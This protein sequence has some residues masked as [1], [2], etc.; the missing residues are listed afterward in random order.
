MAATNKSSVSADQYSCPVCLEV[1]KEPVTLV[2]GHS[3]CMDCIND[4]WDKSDKEETY[5][6]PQCR[7]TFNER[8]ELNKNTVLT[9][10]IEKLKES[11]DDGGDS[12][13]YAGP[14]DVPCDVC[15][16]RKLRAVKSCLTCMAS[17]CETHLQP[18]RRSEVLNRHKLEDPSGNLEEK[19]CTKHQEV[20]KIFC[21]T[22]DT[23]V[24]LLCA[25]TEHKS[26]DTVTPEEARAERQCQV[27]ERKEETK[28]KI[29]EKEKKLE[30]IKDAIEKI[31]SS[32][33]REVE[34]LEEAFKSLLKT[35]E[36][37]RSE[38]TEVIRG[39]ERREVTKAEELI[40]QLEEDIKELKRR[41]AEL[42]ELSQTDDHIHFLK[43]LPSIYFLLGD[44]ETGDIS[45]NGDLLPETLKMSLS[46]LKENLQEINGWEFL[47]TSEPGPDVSGHIL[48]NLQTRNGL[49]KYSCPL[50]LDPNTAHRNLHLSEE[51]KQVTSEEAEA[52]YPDHPDRFDNWLQVLCREALS[53]TRCYWE[54]EWSG[55]GAAIGVTYKGI[56]RKGGGDESSLGENDK[57]WSLFCSDSGYTAWHNNETTKISVPCSHRIGVYLDCSAGSLSFYSISD[58]MTL[59][60]RFNASFTEPL[61]PG[62]GF[63]WDTSVTICSL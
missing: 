46:D 21:R 12:E 41:N 9:E 37:L 54:L 20:L 31:Q 51:N 2:C 18:H 22:D 39:H 52:S 26:H 34:E 56:E 53:G 44:E 23:C 60:Q 47:K 13:S 1:L 61:Y 17:Y 35:I 45:V 59:L 38:V 28:K 57:S 36:R 10:L 6:C 49:L 33:E 63:E 27:E 58:T 19:L 3:Y 11:K 55:K 5:S 16:G 62:F 8:P 32:A 7:R 50:T 30:E 40:E 4:C 14:K 43:A 29:E 24:C 15:T 42:A 48:Q 25:V